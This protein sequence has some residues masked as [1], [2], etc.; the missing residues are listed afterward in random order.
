MRDGDAERMAKERRDGEP[1][2]EP[3]DDPGLGDGEDPSAPPSA[4]KR[5]RGDGEGRGG[6]QDREG[7]APLVPRLTVIDGELDQLAAQTST[8]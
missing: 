6:E 4:P 2:G 8:R 1:V 5:E 3:A 7:E